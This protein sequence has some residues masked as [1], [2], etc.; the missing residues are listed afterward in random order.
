[1]KILIADDEPVARTLLQKTVVRL[2]HEVVVVDNGTEAIATLL[3]PDG[4]RLAI[5]DWEMPG[6]DGL[7]VCR[8]VR[9]RPSPY[10]Y[11]ILL[12]SRD[13][14][15]DM[16]NA[17]DAGA[18]DFLSKPFNVA[19][20]GARLRS[21]ERVLDLQASLL[22]A[23]AALQHQVSHDRL[24]GLW[25]RGMI[26][27]HLGRTLS[28]SRREGRPVCVMM[29]DVD[30]FKAINDAHGH[31]TG[32]VVLVEIGRRM[33]SVLRGYDG[34]GRYGGEEFLLVVCGDGPQTRCLAER[35]RAVVHA[36]PFTAGA[37]GIPVSA[38]FGLACTSALGYDA[39]A[40][41]QAADRAL[42]D[43]KAAGRNRVEG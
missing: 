18:D 10:V 2:G 20:L 32:D 5:L 22:D 26:L 42:Y 29:A 34:I 1:M 16:V 8:A 15:A 39:A 11:V 21:G 13:K 9:Q 27:D 41:I 40:L 38:S 43:A 37:I 35:V 28:R 30:H 25:N 23:Q 7:T 12:T 24:T 33:Q 17:L 3:A 31:G 19:E 6:A 4:P 14:P 36:T